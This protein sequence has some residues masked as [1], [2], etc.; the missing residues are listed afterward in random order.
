MGSHR[1]MTVAEKYYTLLD[2]CW[3]ANVLISADLDRCFDPEFVA[4]RWQ[5]FRALRVLARTVAREDLT[6]ADA[7]TDGE[8]F[9]TR[10]LRSELWDSVFDEEAAVRYDL[11]IPLRLRYLT[12]ATEDSSR[13]LFVGH[14]SF[15]DG[16]IGITEIQTFVRFLDGQDIPEQQELSAA[17]PPGEQHP[18]QQDRR[19]LIDLLRDL[20]TRSVELG[21][22][23]P[24]WWPEVGRER[25]SR[26]QQIVFEP[27]RATRLV[28]AG[29]VHGSGA[30]STV[31]AAW[32]ASVARHLCD[33]DPAA[34]LQIAVPADVSLPTGDPGRPPSMA[35]AVLG[36]PYRVDIDDVWGLA[37]EVASTIR[38]AL[39]RGE[40]DL[41]FHLT[42]VEHVEDLEAG[43]ALVAAALTAAPP[44]VVVSNM[45]VVDP[46]TDPAW[47]RFVSGQL[48][49]VPNQVVFAATLSYRGQLVHSI[50]TDDNRLPPEQLATLIDGYLDLVQTMSAGS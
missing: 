29:K 36:R 9:T 25:R 30:F 18:W 13:V 10:E 7:G 3:P 2:Q 21:Q 16:R 1:P 49:S 33:A 34:T 5:E 46:G 31:G 6:I 43:K 38:E 4:Q 23:G 35:V 27:E 41:F 28:K 50:S 37:T 45:G 14:H 19:E 11:G 17:P 15:L 40:A 32:L 42:R 22:P 44:C 48:P 39:G 26:L 47:L 8:Y 24:A 12:S 20:K